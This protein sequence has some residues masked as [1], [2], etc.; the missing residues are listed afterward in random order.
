MDAVMRLFNMRDDMFTLERL[1]LSVDERKLVDDIIK[2]LL[3]CISCWS[4][5]SG[6]TTTLYSIL[7]SLSSPERKIITIEDPVEYQFPGITK[8]LLLQRVQ[9]K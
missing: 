1:G 7:R 9:R 8:Y 5:G 3:D 6:K 2:N 4:T